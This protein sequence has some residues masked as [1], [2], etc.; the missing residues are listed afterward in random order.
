MYV[1]LTEEEIERIS[2]AS[3]TEPDLQDLADKIRNCKREQSS[4]AADMCRERAELLATDELNIDDDAI[5][6]FGTEKGLYIMAWLWVPNDEE[7]EEGADEAAILVTTPRA[8][9]PVVSVI[10]NAVRAEAARRGLPDN[11]LHI[12]DHL[13]PHLSRMDEWV[14]GYNFENGPCSLVYR[15][16]TDDWA[17]RDPATGRDTLIPE[18]YELVLELFPPAL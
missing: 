7:G 6:S 11:W 4:E 12:S 3:R 2:E 13:A 16:R 10:W 1:N 17:R 5:V 15:P 14:I 8:I 18:N 9:P